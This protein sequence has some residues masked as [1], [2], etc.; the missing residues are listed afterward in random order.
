MCFWYWCWFLWESNLVLKSFTWNQNALVHPITWRKLLDV[1]MWIYLFLYVLVTALNRWSIW[2][3]SFKH[4]IGKISAFTFFTVYTSIFLGIL[5]LLRGVNEL[6][7]AFLFMLLKETSGLICQ[8][9]KS[10]SHTWSCEWTYF[11]KFKIK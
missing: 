4:L 1:N 3:C 2:W 9:L 10:I 7:S 5:E 8:I 6:V 11:Q